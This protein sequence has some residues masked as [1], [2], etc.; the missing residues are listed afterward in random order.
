MDLGAAVPSFDLLRLAEDCDGQ[1]S[2]TAST[3][4]AVS[5]F[6]EQPLKARRFSGSFR[7][8][9]SKATST[10]KPAWSPSDSSALYGVDGGWGAGYFTV[11]ENGHLLVKP[12][13][14]ERRRGDADGCH[15]PRAVLGCSN[16]WNSL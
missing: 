4:S 10:T 11:G 7:S 9:P 6:E 8:S 3:H 2:L 12:H 16:T 13:G 5:D 14:G 15:P 1:S